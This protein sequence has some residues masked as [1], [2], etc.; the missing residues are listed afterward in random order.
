MTA[1]IHR[2]VMLVVTERSLARWMT[3]AVALTAALVLNAPI[4][5]GGGV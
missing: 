4:I 3:V 5:G 1:Q 2:F